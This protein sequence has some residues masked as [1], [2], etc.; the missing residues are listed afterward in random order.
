MDLFSV[1]FYS[2][3]RDLADRDSMREQS[4]VL[5]RLY[6]IKLG[7][8][9]SILQ[10]GRTTLGQIIG[11]LVLGRTKPM[12]HNCPPLATATGSSMGKF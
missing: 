2:E 12:P 7:M 1:G 8:S 10:S 6:S 3:I 9:N 4:L 11:P 5:D